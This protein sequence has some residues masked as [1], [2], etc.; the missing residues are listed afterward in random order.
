MNADEL[1]ERYERLRYGPVANQMRLYTVGAQGRP[2]DTA[3][4]AVPPCSLCGNADGRRGRKTL[5]GVFL[6]S[7]CEND[8]PL[9]AP[10]VLEALRGHDAPPARRRTAMK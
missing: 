7:K 8:S 5:N 9:W 4:G 2:V 10:T 1:E 3:G 6:C